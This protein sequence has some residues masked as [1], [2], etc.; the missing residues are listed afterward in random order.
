LEDPLFTDY[1]RIAASMLISEMYQDIPERRQD[2]RRANYENRS[3][4][5][6]LHHAVTYPDLDKASV[7]A[8][9]CRIFGIEQG[10]LIQAV[11]WCR[12]QKYFG[13]YSLDEYVESLGPLGSPTTP[14]PHVSFALRLL[15]WDVCI[16]EPNTIYP[17]SIRHGQGTQRERLDTFY[18]VTRVVRRY[19]SETQDA[20][21]DRYT[22]CMFS[23]EAD[24]RFP[25]RALMHVLEQHGNHLPSMGWTRTEAAET[26]TTLAS[27][28]ERLPERLVR[29]LVQCPYTPNE[30]LNYHGLIQGVAKSA[31]HEVWAATFIIACR[32]RLLDREDKRLHVDQWVSD[33]EDPELMLAAQQVLSAENWL[34][35]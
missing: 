2:A 33:P 17:L 24:D 5:G 6:W 9:V 16:G 4:G 25:E 28:V 27:H 7:L 31:E 15:H 30:R 20:V 1:E 35:K 18:M 14:L 29:A 12:N 23:R 32:M 26:Y 34:H 11:K 10:R 8:M 21:N 22:D 3:V 13:V 19:M